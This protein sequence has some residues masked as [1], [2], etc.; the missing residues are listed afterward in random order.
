L[1]IEDEEKKEMMKNGGMDQYMYRT[2]MWNVLWRM[3][4]GDGAVAPPFV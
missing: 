4:R 1:P 2:D 3:R